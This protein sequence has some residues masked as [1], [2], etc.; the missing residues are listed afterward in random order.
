MAE[1]NGLLNRRTGNT[2][3]GVRIPLSPPI[4]MRMEFSTIVLDSLIPCEHKS[5]PDQGHPWSGCFIF[6]P[7]A[8][9]LVAQVRRSD[10]LLQFDQGF[11][12]PTFGEVA[13]S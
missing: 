3:P 12:T 13:S 7:P 6:T 5:Y 4:D 1:R 9:S 8:L 10:T 2:V 11:C